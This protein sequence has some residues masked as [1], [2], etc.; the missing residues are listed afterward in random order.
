MVRCALPLM[1]L[2]GVVAAIHAQDGR[3][4]VA[5]KG[6]RSVGVVNPAA[7]SVPPLAFA[8]LVTTCGRRRNRA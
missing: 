7:G 1:L 5:Q 2:V 4:L 8:V 6:D 3:L